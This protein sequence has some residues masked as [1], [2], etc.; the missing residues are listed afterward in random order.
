MKALHT[1]TTIARHPKRKAVC[2][3]DTGPSRRRDSVITVKGA[4]PP[5][6]DGSMHV[7]EEVARDAHRRIGIRDVRALVKAGRDGHRCDV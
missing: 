4:I 5:N 3:I 7:R 1:Y 2:R 6:A